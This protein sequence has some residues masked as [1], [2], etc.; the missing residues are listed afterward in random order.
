LDV[1]SPAAIFFDV[2]FTLIQPGPRFQGSGYQDTC[3][4]H[5]IE[6]DPDRFD[7]AVAAAAPFL[8]SDDGSYDHG[9]FENYTQR[10]IELMCGPGTGRGAAAVEAPERSGIALAARELIQEW[11]EHRHFTLY[12][13]VSD[14]LR[15]LQAMGVRLGL[16]SNTHRCLTSFES[17]F[18]LDGLI[19]AAV[20]S[21][22][23]GFMK[24]HPSIFRAAL[25][26]MGVPP[27]DAM[28]VGDSLVHDVRGAE[29]V[30]MRGILL[31]RGAVAVEVA[32]VPVIRSLAELPAM[33]A[34]TPG[35]PLGSC[36]RA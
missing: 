17:H 11:A 3:A 24:P 5:G 30:G 6:V 36:G 8:E 18:A 14:A 29:A 16:I 4:R 32:N 12:P 31:A 2:D 25:D 33:V 21:S 22:E 23:H 9:V 10:I 27:E 35:S 1:G 15:A 28:M 7:D 34:G 13:E 26:R 19:S 20:S